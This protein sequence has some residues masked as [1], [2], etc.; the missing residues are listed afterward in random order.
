MSLTEKR[1]LEIV[2]RLPT[3]F[4]KDEGGKGNML[5]FRVRLSPGLGQAD[6]A[7]SLELSLYYADKRQVESEDQ[8]I[9]NLMDDPAEY[10]LR[11]PYS[12]AE[13]TFRLEKVVEVFGEGMKCAGSELCF[14]S[15]V[16]RRK[17]GR[18]FR[19]RVAVKDHPEIAPAFTSAVMVMS[20]RK[21]G[22]RQVTRRSRSRS[23]DGTDTAGLASM[24]ES[25]RR[26]I[27]QSID[28]VKDHMVSKLHRRPTH[29]PC[30]NSPYLPSPIELKSVSYGS[31]VKQHDDIST[32]PVGGKCCTT[33]RLFSPFGPAPRHIHGSEHPSLLAWLQHG[34]RR[35]DG[36]RFC[37]ALV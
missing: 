5:S 32:N 12:E 30:F 19:V 14:P 26:E 20:K 22:E 13:V 7:L 36:A 15:Q 9:L 4:Y 6:K 23:V 33:S 34:I 27:K 31:P 21:A 16:S 8:S 29:C 1:R 37:C 24:L 17:D 25:H 10:E 2:D 3:E 11:H 35:W 18:P 28:S